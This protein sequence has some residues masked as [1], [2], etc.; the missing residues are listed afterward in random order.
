MAVKQKRANGGE[1]FTVYVHGHALFKLRGEA[2]EW[3]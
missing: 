3:D 2:R 1:P